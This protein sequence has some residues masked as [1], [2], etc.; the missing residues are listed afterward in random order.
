MLDDEAFPLPLVRIRNWNVTQ[1]AR[2][3]FRCEYNSDTT[4][5]VFII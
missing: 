5:L 2:P 1:F 3:G 4:L